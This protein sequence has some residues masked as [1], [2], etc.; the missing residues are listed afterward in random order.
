MKILIEIPRW[1]GDAVMATP[2]I[3]LLASHY[4]NADITLFGSA[5]SIEVLS[6]APYIKDTIIDNTK[7]YPFRVVA[8]YR[9]FGDKK[10]DIAISFRSH[11]YSNLLLLFSG[12][13]KRAI[14]KPKRYKNVHQVV[15]YHRF[16]SQNMGLGDRD[17]GTL[18]LYYKP[19]KLHKKSIGINPGASYGSAKRWYPQKFAEV[20]LA[21][22]E[23]YDIIIFGSQAEESIANDI[24]KYLQTEDVQNRVTNLVGKTTIAELCAIIGGLELFITG[25]S[26]PM[27]IATAYNIPTIALFGPTKSEETSPWKNRASYIIR[28]KLECAPCMK[29]E[30]PIKTHDCM[31]LITSQEVIKRAQNILKRSSF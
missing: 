2:A 18:K 5:I 6:K 9:L 26:G 21:F 31:R 14:F 15:K 10:F 16:I 8:L 27:H 17:I 22:V 23:E 12:A 24:M 30:C 11:I 4:K 29:R 19:K 28:H 7:D 13:K 20:I 3:E 25:D 1:L